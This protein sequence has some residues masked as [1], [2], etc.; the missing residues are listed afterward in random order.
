[1]L[2]PQRDGEPVELRF[3][4]VPDRLIADQPV[5]PRVE[6]EQLLLA[7]DV[8][9]RHHRSPVLHLGELVAGLRTDA[10]GGRVDGA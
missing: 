7:H 4:H 5:H 2:V 3:E 10:L 1:M 9:E 8:G 6:L